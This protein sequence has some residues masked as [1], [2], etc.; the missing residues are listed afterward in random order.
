VILRLWG[1]I[2][3]VPKHLL[4]QSA[5]NAVLQHMANRA[6]P[7]GRS[8]LALVVS[9]VS[10]LGLLIWQQTARCQVLPTTDSVDA[11]IDAQANQLVAEMTP[12][13]KVLELLSYC[14]NGIARL[15]IPNLQGGEVLHGVMTGGATCFPQSIAL[16]ATWDPQLV[17]RI[18]AVIAKEARAV[19]VHQGFA[20]MLGIARDPRWGRVEE[21]YGEDPYLVT[22]IGVAYIEGLQG[23]GPDR[24][25]RDHI[26]ATPKH[27]LADGE[28]WA[29][30]NGESFDTS[31]RILREIFMPPFEAAVEIARTESIM[32]AH[33]PIN[34][35]P[36][37]ANKWLLTDLLRNEWGFGGFVT[38]DMGDIPKLFGG[39]KIARSNDEAAILALKA[40]V[41]MELSGGPPKNHIFVSGLLAGLKSGALSVDVLNRAVKRVLKAKIELLG[42]GTPSISAATAIAAGPNDAITNYKGTDDIWAKLVAEGKFS[43]PESARQP[44]YQAVLNDPAHDALALRAAQEAI[45]LLKNEKNLLPLDASRVKD[46]LIVGPLVKQTNLGG[47]STGKPKF[48]VS[49]LDG[50]KTV[51]G[52]G[53]N[54]GYEPGCSLADES[55][56]L[57]SKAVEAAKKADAIIAVVGQS[58]QN[59][60]E[61]LDRDNLDL[62]GGQ[63]A[64]VQA[65]QAS[66][67]P[68]VVV[69]ENGAPLSIG[70]IRDNVPAILETWYLGQSTGTAVAQAL[71]G[72]I[73]PGG[74]LNISF[75]KNVGQVPCYYDHFPITG[76]LNYYKSKSENLFV[77]GQGL[78]YTTFQ[79]SGLKIDP[80]TIKPTQLATV[81]AT[82]RNTGQR[83]GD[84]VVQL[85]IRQDFTSLE[86]PVIELKG[87][88][89]L[90]LKPGESA[91]VSFPIGYD[92]LKFWSGERD[93]RWVVEPGD[94][95][96]KVGS[97]S[98]DVRLKGTLHVSP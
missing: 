58:R 59:A 55:T 22:Q 44:G 53:V 41:D 48:Y 28:P 90:A 67:K 62:I 57:E 51:V 83:A 35:V 2:P 88:K 47:Y 93:G 92:Q 9:G 8:S 3:F 34:G 40:G 95:A 52:P 32:P 61:N 87:F 33:H 49:I 71:F 56:D 66:G 16:G 91:V 45:V 18:A 86:R 1:P 73:N 68:V 42:I 54:V 39:H 63:Q 89:R 30:D 14:P 84:E 78:S 13:E 20:P 77:F 98:Q 4:Q 72:Q 6:N 37:H 38:S 24:L 69:L 79:Y 82:V 94:V 76:P 74:K 7:S 65:M 36:C 27:F 23:M 15:G 81:S 64:L 43:T 17:E 80:P 50:I 31:D 97:S 12:Q 70:W 60:G 85:Y 21:C 29:G 11:R 19:G 5:I 10:M 46:I 75:P 25:G 26:I 96:I